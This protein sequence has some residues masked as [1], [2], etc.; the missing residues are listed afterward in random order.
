MKQDKFFARAPRRS[1]PARLTPPDERLTRLLATIP[2]RYNARGCR[3]TARCGIGRAAT[4]I[5]ANLA[6][7]CVGLALRDGGTGAALTVPCDLA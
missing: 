2:M 1:P 7:R 6:R 4:V 5:R 3:C